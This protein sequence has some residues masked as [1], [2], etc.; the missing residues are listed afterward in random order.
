MRI[1][2]KIGK[3]NTRLAHLLIFLS[4]LLSSC[5]PQ[6]TA[7]SP[8]GAGARER[9][10]SEGR[11]PVAVVEREGDARGAVAVAVTTQGIAPERGA[12]VG[13]ALAALVEARLAA[14]GVEANA[15]GG[16][17]GWR[18][19]A[20][21]ASP[22]DA[23]RMVDEARAA[24]LAPVGE[25]EPA[26]TAVARKAAALAHRPID[27]AI[28]EFARCTGEAFGFGSEATPSA[29][30][31]ES[32]RRAA[33]GLGR[34]AVSTAGDTA[35]ADAVAGALTRA[36]PWPSAAEKK[37]AAWP[38][39]DERAAVYDASGELL[40]GAARVIVTV[41]TALPERAAAAA[42]AL[43]DPRGALASRLGGLETPARV[44]S[45][46]ATAHSDGG[47]VAA[48]IDMAA[49]DLAIDAPARIATAA[50][51]ARQE[52][53]TEV[54]D[55]PVRPGIGRDLALRAADP[56]DAAERAAWW[57][58]AA[59]HPGALDGEQQQ[60][61]SVAVGIAAARDAREAPRADA[62]RA[63]IDHATLAWHAPVVE[64]RTRVERGQ[65]EAWVVVAS[66][67][68]TMAE[69]DGDAG[70]GAA[71]AAAAAEQASEKATCNAR[72]EAVAAPDAIGLVAHGPACADES[73][74]AHAHRLADLAARTFAAD[75][76]D[77]SHVARARTLLMARAGGAEARAFSAL[78]S[79]LAPG[80]PSWVAPFGSSFGLASASDD[81]IAMRA[82]AVRAGPLRVA[83]MADVDAAEAEAA[84]RAVD[85]W[86]ARRPG[87][88]RVC[89]SPASAAP[90]HPGTYVADRP[91]GATPEAWLA[92]AL[93]PHDA[94]GLRHAH[95]MAA[96]LDGADGLLARAL[97]SIPGDAHDDLASA[98]GASIAGEPRAPALVVRLAAAG[99]S[100]D[101]AVAQTRALFDRLRQG[102]LRDEDVARASALLA[103]RRLGASLD[104]RARVLDLWR[105]PAA[106]GPA[107]PAP[108]L[109]SLRAFAA[110]TLHDHALVIVAA[111]P[112]RMR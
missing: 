46:V 4:S 33:H 23:A 88:S 44:R 8:R 67:C 41:R 101:T 25:G 60:R 79:A 64:A 99:G 78:A 47:C 52:A 77:S 26:M 13:V 56:R 72:V 1:H 48:T 39:A 83:V 42:Q 22:A 107:V 49:R 11:P 74:L 40:P 93:S 27:A 97:G 85:R 103:R 66:P 109:D 81:A 24:M 73:A 87:E 3:R 86:I 28:V 34:V 19:R 38:A 14:R 69:A 50:A 21:V 15:I 94:A 106:S 30:E 36:T 68:G 58:L 112:P 96:A 92:F 18:L 91:A 104:P 76:L 100:L 51:L 20:L 65:G 37:A 7:R 16:W 89:A 5:A 57:S 110:A 35:I 98:W 31:V 55:A 43:G 108:T 10:T 53:A 6:V 80:H 105:S 29:R 75:S 9:V 17:D 111:R 45:V 54:Q 2:A 12:V 82:S 63:A 59:P 32:W 71:V 70:S 84:V 62:V 102:A 61:A 90:P 95:W